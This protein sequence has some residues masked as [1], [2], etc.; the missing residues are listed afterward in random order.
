MSLWHKYNKQNFSHSTSS[1]F[2]AQTYRHEGSRTDFSYF[3]FFPP[4]PGFIAFLCLVASVS[5]P[6][7]VELRE[8]R[9]WGKVLHFMADSLGTEAQLLNLQECTFCV[10][11]RFHQG[12]F[13]LGKC[14][15]YGWSL[16]TLPSPTDVLVSHTDYLSRLPLFFRKFILW[17]KVHLTGPQ[18]CVFPKTSKNCWTRGEMYASLLHCFFSL[19]FFFFFF[20]SFLGLHLRHMEV[21]WLG[22]ES[23]L[24][25]LAYTTATATWAP[26]TVYDLHHRSWQRQILTH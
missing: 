4:H 24:H 19:L 16:F 7:R 9:I 18:V 22:A 8:R 1:F 12:I 20:F 14:L 6:S 21:P 26:S 17:R 13:C 5:D 23:E 15:S 2:S 3:F 11:Q 25:L 10:F